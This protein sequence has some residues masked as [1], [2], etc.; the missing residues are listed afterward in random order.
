MLFLLG[1]KDLAFA[2]TASYLRQLDLDEFLIFFFNL[3]F[4]MWIN[5]AYMQSKSFAFKTSN[6]TS[7]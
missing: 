2:S 7:M 4:C 6:S 1:H 3:Q 5:D